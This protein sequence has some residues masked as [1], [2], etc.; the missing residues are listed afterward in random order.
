MADIDLSIRY[1][2]ADVKRLESDLEDIRQKAISVQTS[3][4]GINLKKL[5]ASFKGL[6]T[7]ISKTFGRTITSKISAVTK[8][9]NLQAIAVRNLAAEYEVLS[10]G[11]TVAMLKS[12]KI[13]PAQYGTTSQQAPM[14]YGVT[15]KSGEW[16]AA[17]GGPID[18]EKL[19]KSGPTGYREMAGVS[20][21]EKLIKNGPRGYKELQADI[22]T[23]TQ[24]EKIAMRRLGVSKDILNTEMSTAEIAKKYGVSQ[25]TIL[26]DKKAIAEASMNALNSERKLLASTIHPEQIGSGYTLPP[27]KPKQAFPAQ[28]ATTAGPGIVPRKISY[29]D[30]IASGKT[31]MAQQAASATIRDLEQQQQ[32]ISQIKESYESLGKIQPLEDNFKKIEAQSKITSESVKDN[33]NRMWGVS[34]DAAQKA[35]KPLETIQASAQKVN[36]IDISKPFVSA[37]DELQVLSRDLDSLIR[38]SS[39]ASKSGDKSKA[40]QYEKEI[41]QNIERQGQLREKIRNQNSMLEKQVKTEEK[42][43]K[44]Q[45]GG[46]KEQ[47]QAATE[48]LAIAKKTADEA[49]KAAQE[50]MQLL[51]TEDKGQKAQKNA[52]DIQNA[53]DKENKARISQAQTFTDVAK[54]YEHAQGRIDAAI[55]KAQRNLSVIPQGTKENQAQADAFGELKKLRLDFAKDPAAAFKTYQKDADRLFKTIEDGASQAQKHMGFMNSRFAK[56]SIIMSGLAAT[57]FVW[58]QLSTALKAIISNFTEFENAFARV[59][60]G[61]KLSVEEIKKFKE[62]AREAGKT[63]V[64][65]GAQYA[66][67]VS[68]LRKYGMSAEDAQDRVNKMIQRQQGMMEGTLDEQITQFKGLTRDIGISAGESPGFKSWLKD[69]NKEIK[70]IADAN[71]GLETTLQTLDLFGKLGGDI[72][73]WITPSSANLDSATEAMNEVYDARAKLEEQAKTNRFLFQ[74][75][76]PDEAIKRY[77]DVMM[78]TDFSVIEITQ[79]VKVTYDYEPTAEE[80]QQMI[81]DLPKDQLKAAEILG[82]YVGTTYEEGLK[83]IKL[84]LANLSRN[85]GIAQSDLEKIE[86]VMIGRLKQKELDLSLVDH[87]KY[88][89]TLRRYSDEYYNNE[90]ERIKQTNKERLNRGFDPQKSK[91]IAQKEYELLNQRKF[92]S[93]VSSEKKL[94]QTIG[95]TSGTKIEVG[96]SIDPDTGEQVTKMMD[97]MEYMQYQTEKAVKAMNASLGT[98]G[99]TIPTDFESAG[100]PR[101]TAAILKASKATGVDP[102]IL[103]QIGRKESDN[104]RADIV[105]GDTLSPKGAIGPMQLLPKTARELGVDP[106]NI[107]ENFMGGA[108]YFKQMLDEF[109]NDFKLALA[110]YNAGPGRVKEY[111]NQVPPFKETQDYVS[112]I[113]KRYQESKPREDV[114]FTPR[115][116]SLMEG[117][118]VRQRDWQTAWQREQDFISDQAS[119]AY[120]ISIYKKAYDKLGLMTNEYYQNELD[121]INHFEEQNRDVLGEGYAKKI[122]DKARFNLKWKQKTAEQLKVGQDAL[123]MMEKNFQETGYYSP[124]LEKRG[125]LQI[126]ETEERL[127]KTSLPKNIQQGIVDTKKLEEYENINKLRVSIDQKYFDESKIMTDFLYEYKKQK[128]MDEVKIATEMSNGKIDA[129]Q[130]LSDKLQ[131]LEDERGKNRM[132]AW[133]A[134]Y[135]S[136]GKYSEKFVESEIER[137]ERVRKE[138]IRLT[139]DV[140][141]A[142]E[143]AKRSKTQIQMEVLLKTENATNGLDALRKEMSLKTETLA[144]AVAKNVKTITEGVQENL[145][146]TIYDSF[147]GNF[148]NVWDLFDSMVD[149]FKQMIDKMVA[150]YLASQL[151]KGLFGDMVEG[152]SSGSKGL[153]GGLFDAAMKGFGSYMGGGTAAASSSAATSSLSAYQFAFAKGGVIDKPTKFTKMASGGMINDRMSSGAIEIGEAGPEAVLPLKRSRF[154]KLG[155]LTSSGITLELKRLASGNLGIDTSL[156]DG[157]SRKMAKGGIITK[158]TIFYSSQKGVRRFASGG[159]IDNLTKR[160]EEAESNLSELSS[161]TS[162]VNPVE[163]AAAPM[164]AASPD[165]SM[166]PTAQ[167]EQQITQSVT[168]P[169]ISSLESAAAPM[170]SPETSNSFESAA[171]P[172]M[173]WHH[174][175][176]SGI[177]TQLQSGGMS[178]AVDSAAMGAVGSGQAA[179][180]QWNPLIPVGDYKNLAL[181]H[182]ETNSDPLFAKVVEKN[183][184]KAMDKKRNEVLEMQRMG[185][186]IYLSGLAKK[187]PAA[188]ANKTAA[189]SIEQFLSK[190]Y[191]KGGVINQNM[192]S[193]DQQVI[194]KKQTFRPENTTGLSMGG[195]INKRTVFK[196]GD[197][198]DH[199]ASGGIVASAFQSGGGLEI[200][201]RGPEVVM[202]ITKTSSGKLGV[203]AVQSGGG[204]SPNVHNV[205]NITVSA[206]KGKIDQN[207]MNQLQTKLGMSMQRAMRRN[208]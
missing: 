159:V 187:T 119:K 201:E 16:Y 37:K 101:I 6:G 164:M 193:I 76:D 56:F 120:D 106:F 207:S 204:G 191:A 179:Q 92:S 90:I 44:N 10:A 155:V 60:D 53:V 153:L 14:Q 96:I 103:E 135:D 203:A 8:A 1:N 50:P 130:M 19:Y 47:V 194:D 74:L 3:L 171:A 172:M 110:A 177:G 20:D 190:R 175:L 70:D 109:N 163:S 24:A 141:L 202:P 85:K 112:T 152:G 195:I 27:A 149:R 75:E 198:L 71:G 77:K 99:S 183:I 184:Q 188:P 86:S 131:A 102:Y 143:M 62:Q 30:E 146:T 59:R 51:K 84:L 197:Y 38:K 65:T 18:Y 132:D 81:K 33:L 21:Y 161:G 170:I 125:E 68:Q 168:A 158:P 136:T 113:T 196:D 100:G 45:T 46:Y 185:G 66:E 58:Q 186:D 104:F 78:Q 48:K 82:K 138:M 69:V 167:P 73:K 162:S 11:R 29:Q 128:I 34:P 23:A 123:Q 67:M 115:M 93:F 208:S 156:F 134:M 5:E 160:Q 182:I 13:G 25:S 61:L 105:S 107:E 15:G 42:L 139:G 147:Q 181:P 140:D 54:K 150:D 205:F 180:H 157:G 79:P 122:A 114:A 55:I 95:V 206:P 28:Y 189:A 200:G 80:L 173:D 129:E 98:I 145:S 133:K 94:L 97:Y 148:E 124:V 144:E 22:G 88:Y 192:I 174:N 2:D 111:G 32:K 4:D 17:G 151:A 116:Q 108:K 91:Q 64:I 166:M 178:F 39:Q 35:T 165:I 63:G 89:N 43:I 31:A 121:I 36:D 7:T 126:K 137:I 142:N 127:A 9:I 26:R 87:K 49:E 199:M 52:Q 41:T 72:L 83:E 40:A 118:S 176:S 117:P 154:G 169:E 57:M 12:E